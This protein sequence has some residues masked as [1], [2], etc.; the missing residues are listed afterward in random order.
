MCG[1]Q[2]TNTRNHSFATEV[3]LRANVKLSERV[4]EGCGG[5]RSAKAVGWKLT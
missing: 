3:V 4:T 5:K 1:T 2:E